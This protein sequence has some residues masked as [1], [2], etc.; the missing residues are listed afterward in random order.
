[1][2][3]ANLTQ[4]V[5]SHKLARKWSILYLYKMSRFCHLVL[6]KPCRTLGHCCMENWILLNVTQV[7]SNRTLYQVD[8]A[9]RGSLLAYNNGKAFLSFVTMK[10]CD[11]MSLFDCTYLYSSR[12]TSKHFSGCGQTSLNHL[13]LSTN[14]IASAFI[15]FSPT[16]KAT[17]NKTSSW[18]HRGHKTNSVDWQILYHFSASVLSSACCTINWNGLSTEHPSSTTKSTQY[19][20]VACNSLHDKMAHG[21]D[22]LFDNGVQ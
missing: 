8:V 14:K 6:Y 18:P 16:S 10:P 22:M 1:M 4:P 19:N 3:E 20:F 2:V 12:K 11:S 21:S 9:S 5:N 17:P 7:L 15:L 13:F